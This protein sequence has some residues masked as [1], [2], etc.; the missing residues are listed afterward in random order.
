MRSYGRRQKE[1]EEDTNDDTTT[2]KSGFRAIKVDFVVHYTPTNDLWRRGG[3][4]TVAW[5]LL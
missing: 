1:E 2:T 4:G 3:A 5:I